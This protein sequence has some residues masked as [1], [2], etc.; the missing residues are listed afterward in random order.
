MSTLL[1]RLAAPIQAWGADSKFDRRITSREPT[2]S[3]VIGMLAAAL[4]RRR[5][6]PIDDLAKL[7][8]GVRIDQPGQLLKD[9]HTTRHTVSKPPYVSVRYYLMDAVFL[10]GLEGASNL[11]SKLEAAIS[12]PVFPLYLGRRSCPPAGRISLGQRETD[13]ERALREEL[14]QAS[15]WYCSRQ[16]KSDKPHYL[17]LVIDSAEVGANR[18][19]DIPLSFSQDHRQHAYRYIDNKPKAVNA[20]DVCLAIATDHDPVEGV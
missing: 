12:E 2:K 13:L 7:G 6:E 20:R 19:R 17:T 4:G 9:F 15:D 11:L 3:G 1:L 5:D 16:L 18:Q 14:W 8:F 10:V